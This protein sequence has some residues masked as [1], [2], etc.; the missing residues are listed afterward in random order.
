MLDGLGLDPAVWAILRSMAI[1]LILLAF[2]IDGLILG[3]VLP[4][5]AMYIAYVGLVSMTT[6]ATVG[7]T[8][9]CIA[10]STLGQWTL[11]RWL[12]RDPAAVNRRLERI[13]YLIRITAYTRRRV[14]QRRLAIISRN[15]DRFGGLAIGVSNAI[16]GIRSLMTIPAGL[17]SYPQRRFL[18]F[19]LI[20]NTGYLVL[21][22]LI[23]RGIVRL[24]GILPSL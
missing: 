15:F 7:F 22:W 13:P 18:L 3:K 4:P 2:Y 19:S 24:A 6:V 11:Y 5:A 20:G 1:P 23:A 8:V 9:A 17:S 21:L 10:A 14:G 16:P 12:K